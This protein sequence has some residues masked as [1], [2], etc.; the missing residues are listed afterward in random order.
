MPNV[1]NADLVPD[2]K[3][4]RSLGVTLMTL[5]RWTRDPELRFPKRIKIK[6]RNYRS[7]REL[8]AWRERMVRKSMGKVRT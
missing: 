7:Q 5:W 2:P 4:A 3:V 6:T 8:D 1:E